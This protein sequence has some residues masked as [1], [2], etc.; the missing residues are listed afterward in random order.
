M[1]NHPTISIVTICYNSAAGIEET[2]QSVLNQDYPAIDYVIVDGGSTDGTLEIIEKY[3][4]RLGF[5]K[6]E[7]DEG[8]SDAFNKGVAAAKG[9]LIV[10][11]NSDDILLPGALQAVAQAYDGKTD[12]Y[13]GNV[14]I[15][16]GTDGFRGREIPSMR[17]PLAP[18]RIHCAHQG[19][20]ITPEAYRKYGGYDKKF[21]Y[22]M[23]F[24]L[25][26]R[27]YQQGATFK[28]VDADIAEFRLGGVSGAAYHKKKYD[29]LHVVVN[30]GG[31]WARAYAYYAYMVCYDAL[32]HLIIRTF[33]IN[34]LKRWHYGK[35]NRQ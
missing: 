23:D 9:E 17:F 33:G 12:V 16:N 31:S 32:R 11:I 21:R 8:I 6:S 7:P 20:F 29:I 4:N 25:L 35:L 14:I 27:F 22:M 5:F 13:R 34:T 28:R 30:N 19:T 15:T 1:K 26:T 10:M 3:R 18:L 24:D 2:I